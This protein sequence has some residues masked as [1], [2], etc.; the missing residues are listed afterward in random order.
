[1]DEPNID[2]IECRLPSTQRIREL[3]EQA[4]HYSRK[5]A[6]LAEE[7]EAVRDE[8]LGILSERLDRVSPGKTDS[9]HENRG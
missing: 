1:M 5:M 2:P 4:H 3:L 6:A 7:L 8:L 9:A